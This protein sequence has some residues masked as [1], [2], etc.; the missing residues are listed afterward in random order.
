MVGRPDLDDSDGN[1]SDQPE[2]AA[3]QVEKILGASARD[4]LASDLIKK[5]RLTDDQV[6]PVTISLFTFIL[7]NSSFPYLKAIDSE[8][9]SRIASGNFKKPFTSWKKDSKTW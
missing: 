2:T 7:M 5:A 9:N 1:E 6:W 4:S 3:E 8:M